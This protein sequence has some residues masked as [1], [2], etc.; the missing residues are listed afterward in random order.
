MSAE[1]ILRK[2][3]NGA[4]A[5]VFQTEH[6][7]VLLTSSAYD[8][9]DTAWRRLQSARMM[10]R[11]DRNYE[12]RA[13][14]S[15]WLYFVVMNRGKE[16]LAQSEPY[17]GRESLRQGMLL[18]KGC[19]HGARIVNPFREQIRQCRREQ[20]QKLVLHHSSYT[21]ETPFGCPKCGSAMVLKITSKRPHRGEHFWG[22]SNYPRCNGFLEYNLAVEPEPVHV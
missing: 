4:F 17:L 15:G 19:S 8:N 16:V 14:D 10:A 6:G 22:C 3:E 9:P 11:K 20:F 7:Q 21:L 1:F 5:F 12:V 2:D 13:I 18:T